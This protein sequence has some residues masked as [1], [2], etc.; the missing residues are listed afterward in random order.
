MTTNKHVVITGSTRGIGYG[1]AENFLRRGCSVTVSGRSQASADQAAARLKSGTEAERVLALACDVTDPAQ[2]QRLWDESVVKFGKVDSW[3]NN[4]GWSGEEGS[5]WERPATEVASV[6]ITNLV[7]T[8]YGAQIAMRGMASQGFGAIYN[9]EGMG[10]DGRKHAGLTTYGTS[11]YGVHYFT[12]SLA[13]EARDTGVIVGSLRPG[14]VITAMIVDRYKD[15][16]ADWERAR[17]I[18]N[19]IAERTETVTPWLVDAMLANQKNGAVLSFSSPWKMLWKFASSQFV[20]RDLF[21]DKR[22]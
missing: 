20:K 18:F 10:S 21:A 3:I 16:P 17:K 13:L 6:L 9:M 4:A 14:M 2:I 5:V 7:G 8:A 22:L 11:K 12:E 1:L 15:R 19:I